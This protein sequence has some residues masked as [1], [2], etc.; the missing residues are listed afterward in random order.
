MLDRSEVFGEAH[1]LLHQTGGFGKAAEDIHALHGLAAG[2]FD[3]VVLGAHHDEPAGARVEPPGDFDD[4][5][6]DDI[7]RVGQGFAFQQPHERFVA[8]GGLV[9][10]GDFFGQAQP[11]PARWRNVLAGA[12]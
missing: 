12:R 6:A 7:F 5:R 3:D 10:G 4:V 9:A 2:A 11:L 1:V 8:V